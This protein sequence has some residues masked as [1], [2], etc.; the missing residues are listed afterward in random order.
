[1]IKSF[2]IVSEHS[3]TCLATKPLQAKICWAVSYFA[4][5]GKHGTIV[6]HGGQHGGQHGTRGCVTMGQ[7]GVQQVHG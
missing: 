6:Q 7:Q 1:M 2:A 5:G 4:S 3:N